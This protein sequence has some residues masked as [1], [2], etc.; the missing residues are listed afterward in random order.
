MAQ[1]NNT[2]V[3]FVDPVTGTESFETYS[4]NS[5]DDL[6]NQVEYDLQEN[7]DTALTSTSI[8]QLY[9]S[10]EVSEYKRLDD[11]VKHLADSIIKSAEGDI[12]K[13]VGMLDVTICR[14]YTDIIARYVKFKSKK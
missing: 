11:A 3:W 13:I 10:Y 7:K 1:A 6:I 5:K 14:P 8:A 2:D 12:Q 4:H 9:D